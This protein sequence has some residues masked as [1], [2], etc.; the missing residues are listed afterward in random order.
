MYSVPE[1]KLEL[2]LSDIVA[3]SHAGVV[4]LPDGRVVIP[5]NK[6]KQL[7]VLNV[8]GTGA[9]QVSK[10][11]PVPITG[12]FL[13]T[14]VDPTGRYFL[15]TSSEEGVQKTL[16]LIDLQTDAA[17]TFKVDNRQADA[18]LSV[19]VGGTPATVYLH[20]A[21]QVLSYPLAN[22]L[23]AAPDSLVQGT[24]R[25][26][27]T[28]TVGTGGHGNAFSVATGRWAGSTAR[29]FELA[30]ARG[31]TLV[32]LKTLPW[33]ITTFTGGQ[34]FRFRLTPDG[35]YVFGPINA[36]QEAANWAKTNVDLHWTNLTRGTVQRF[37]LTTGLV[38]RAGVSKTLAVY[39]NLTGAGDFAQFVNVDPGSP[40]FQKVTARVALGTLK[41]GPQAGVS[42]A[43]TERRFPAIS[44]DGR[45]A[46][47]SAGGEGQIAVIDTQTYQVTQ[48]IAVP[49]ALKGGGYLVSV[50]AGTNL[51]E[52]EG[53]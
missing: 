13:W 31:D 32:N 44:A 29:G 49:T 53:R 43:G 27:S 2:D 1:F 33:N 22:L 39:A 52:L 42:A 8:G 20:T 17:R 23:T 46:F 35:R 45:W 51:P 38:T 15:S 34:N 3:A 7:I 24:L 47:V 5:D 40:L 30:Q 6:H 12:S 26:T 37:P 4:T 48:Q 25:P 19:A 16:S 50:Q 10:R 21:D 41:A 18:E 28:L 9:P 36:P 11:I 14:A